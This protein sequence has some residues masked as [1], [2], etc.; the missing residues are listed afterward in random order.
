MSDFRDSV[1]APNGITEL[2]CNVAPFIFSMSVTNM[3]EKT[4][5]KDILS[6]SKAKEKTNINHSSAPGPLAQSLGEWH[7]DS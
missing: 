5:R 4:Q 2:R 6:L 3:R 1:F 7:N